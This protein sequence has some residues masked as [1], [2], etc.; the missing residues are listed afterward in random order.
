MESVTMR[1]KVLL[2]AV[3]VLIF[4]SGM[5]VQSVFKITPDMISGAEKLIGLE[6]TPTE[7]DSM[8]DLLNDQLGNYKNIHNY[9]LKNS[10][11]PALYFNPIPTG[12]RVSNN[13]KPIKW[14]QNKKA[15]LPANPDDLAFYS[16]T[17]LSELIKT[18]Q[19]T[20]EKLT[21]FYIDRLKKYGPKL[22]CTIT[23][24]EDLAIQQAKQ[25]DKE[26]A[27]GKYRGMLHGIPYGIKDLLS[28][29]T[30]KTT[31]GSVAYKDQVI[32]EDAEVVKR[33]TSA[34]AILTAKLTLGELAMDDV[35][36]GGMTRNPWNYEEGSSGSSAGPASATAAGLLAFTIGS[37]TW[38]SIVSPSTRCGTTGLRPT[39]GRISRT[40]AMALSWS[41]DKLGP[42]CRT[43]EDCAI[44]FDAIKGSDGIDKTLIDADFNYDSNIDIKKLKIG[45]LK[46]DFD[47]VKTGKEFD[48]ATLEVLRKMGVQLIPVE[49]PKF[50]VNDLAIILSAEASAAFDDLTRSN[51]DDLL[52]RQFK[53]AWPNIFRSGRFIPAVE[54]IQANRIRYELIQSMEKLMNQVDVYVAPNFVGD[55]LLLTN[56]SGHPCVVLPNGFNKNGTPTSITV[57][58]KLFGE[59]ELLGVAKKIQTATDFHLKHPK[60]I[61]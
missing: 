16:I 9:E 11:P 44:V 14:E 13:Q 22:E 57:I 37:E 59:A 18:K 46:N 19:I 41:M 28:T 20:S 33:L 50:P 21:R 29:K 54:Y 4:L 12:F 6:F 1:S 45:Y 32:D 61:L 47:S 34:G 25:A 58:G 31:W 48:S 56:L 24:T 55:N 10:T 35:W 27:A 15:K 52:V 43:V 38:G 3:A 30:Y 51:R 17:D 42:I 26:I 49:L 7:R 36:F 40:G 5:M 53:Y 60:L 39:Y 2:I 8:I 23:L